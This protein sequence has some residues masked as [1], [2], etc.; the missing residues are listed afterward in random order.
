FKYI[1]ADGLQSCQLVMGLTLLDTGSV[2]N[3][4]PAHL[5]SRRMEV[6]FYFD[7]P[8]GQR[9]FHLMGEPQET[10]HIV[11]SNHEA[12]ISPPWS[13]HSGCGTANYGFIWGMAGENRD[14]TDVDAVPLT[15]L[16]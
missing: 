9:V 2:W 5:H 12:L 11:V 14:Y 10:R 4:M 3:T 1:H 15:S 7:V 8:D 16:L 6:Y 13:I